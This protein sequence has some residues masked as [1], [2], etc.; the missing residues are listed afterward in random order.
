MY[1]TAAV[2]SRSRYYSEA[3]DRWA[4]EPVLYLNLGFGECLFFFL[5][6]CRIDGPYDNVTGRHQWL[7]VL[8]TESLDS[9]E[10]FLVIRKEAHQAS[11]SQR[12]SSSTLSFQKSFAITPFAH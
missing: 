8:C 7:E 2:S 6:I 4:L 10:C 12:H 3:C 9:D 1:S 5:E 11:L